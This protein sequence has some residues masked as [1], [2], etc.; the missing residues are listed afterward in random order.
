MNG[1]GTGPIEGRPWLSEVF[2]FHVS[3]HLSELLN[4]FNNVNFF[5][6]LLATLLHDALFL[7][8]LEAQADAA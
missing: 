7:V 6:E 2:D 5:V 3:T 8:S 1:T 4:V